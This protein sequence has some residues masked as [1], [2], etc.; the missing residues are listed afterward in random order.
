MLK[1]KAWPIV[2][3][4]L[5]DTLGSIVVGV[6]YLIA[7]IGITG[8]AEPP[9]IVADILGLFMTAIGGF[10]AAR[11]ARTQ[12]IQHGAAVGAGAILVWLLVEWFSPTETL[13]GWD[14]VL[15]FVGIIP[16]GA[17]G[18]YVAAKRANTPHALGSGER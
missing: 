16:A 3:G 13:P 12:P 10:V 1:L 14:A 6:L 18:G 4:I 8:A 15:S 9:L 2:V 11:M 7:V 5:I 17:L